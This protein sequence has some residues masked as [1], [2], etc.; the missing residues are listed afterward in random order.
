MGL[1]KMNCMQYAYNLEK[2]GTE[3]MRILVKVRRF[4]K[5]PIPWV[6]SAS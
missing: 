3:A 6:I 2:E 4:G 5:V 1:V